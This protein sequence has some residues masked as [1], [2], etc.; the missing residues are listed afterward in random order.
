M[1]LRTQSLNEFFAKFQLIAASPTAGI[2]QVNV[3]AEADGTLRSQSVLWHSG[4]TQIRAKAETDGTAIVSNFGK[5]G[6]T[7]TAFALDDNGEQKVAGYSNTSAGAPVADRDDAAGFRRTREFEPYKNVAVVAV[8]TTATTIYTVP[9]ATVSIVEIEL[10]N[11]DTIAN[12]VDL[13]MIPSG[14]SAA[15]GNI[16]LQDYSIGAAS[17]PI[18]LGPYHGGAGVFFQALVTTGGG[19]NGDINAIATVKEFGTGD[20]VALV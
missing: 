15:I 4:T 1:A 20:A 9:A 10:T 18:R 7:L 5:V 11:T 13:H 3:L 12:T 16:I 19:A 6:S 14:G 8:Q 17:I 2:D